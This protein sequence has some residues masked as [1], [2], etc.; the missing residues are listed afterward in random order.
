MLKQ[1]HIA[2]FVKNIKSVQPK[3]QLSFEKNIAGG[4]KRSI[5]RFS[6]CGYSYT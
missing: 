2:A 4:P 3:K 6:L 1:Q 5:V